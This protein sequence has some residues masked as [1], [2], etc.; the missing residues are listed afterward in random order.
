[1]KKT[2]SAAI[3]GAALAVML[4]LAAAQTPASGQDTKATAAG[5]N[6]KGRRMEGTWL[7]G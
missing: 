3:P 4:V 6:A 7:V 5:Q 1:M 2:H